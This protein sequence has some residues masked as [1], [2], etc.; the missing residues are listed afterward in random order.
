[1]NHN[2]KIGC[3]GEE[4]AAEYLQEKGYEFVDKNVRTPYGEIDLIHRLDGI[5]IFVEVKTRTSSR[6]G[7]PEEAITARKQQHIFDSAEHYAQ[8][9]KLEHWQIDAISVE[10]K[11]SGK[12]PKITHFED[13]L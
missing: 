13:I 2:H 10:G 5:T 12:T 11:P 4:I 1:M 9:N 8:E 3:W 6:Y 7:Y